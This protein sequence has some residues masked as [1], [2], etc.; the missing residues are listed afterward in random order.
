MEEK[1]SQKEA[2]IIKQLIEEMTS[3]SPRERTPERIRNILKKRGIPLEQPHVV[4]I[5]PDID[6]VNKELAEKIRSDLLPQLIKT[7]RVAGGL[8]ISSTI[9]TLAK[10]RCGCGC[11]GGDGGG[12]GGT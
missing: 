10:C 6:P 9:G 12:G 4:V 1:E 7:S 3:L 2:M 11:H 8:E 5:G